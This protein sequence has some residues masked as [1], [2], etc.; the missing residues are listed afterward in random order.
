MPKHLNGHVSLVLGGKKEKLRSRFVF[1]LYVVA[2]FYLIWFRF[3]VVVVAALCTIIFCLCLC[4]CL[5]C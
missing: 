4:V 5:L 2:T 1:N 3:V